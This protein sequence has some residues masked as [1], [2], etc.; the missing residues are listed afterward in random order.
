MQWDTLLNMKIIIDEQKNLV[1]FD[2]KEDKI[3]KTIPN[4]HNYYYLADAI[5][6][7]EN[8]LVTVTHNE[9]SIKIWDVKNFSLIK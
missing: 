5:K 1:F 6:L 8:R 9:D 2:W 3:I 4:A 7:D